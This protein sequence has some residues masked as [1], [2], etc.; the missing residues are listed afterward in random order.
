M[1]RINFG[2][3]RVCFQ[4]GAYSFA[5]DKSELHAYMLGVLR[6]LEKADMELHPQVNIFCKTDG[7][8][9]LSNMEDLRAYVAELQGKETWP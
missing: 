8:I 9:V 6:M 7:V 3:S 2:R 4:Q 5:I 1:K